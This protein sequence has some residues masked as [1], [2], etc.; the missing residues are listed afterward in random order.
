MVDFLGSDMHNENYLHALENARTEKYLEKALAS[1]K[2]L[3][4]NL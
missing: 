4:A 2:L 3:N 1:G